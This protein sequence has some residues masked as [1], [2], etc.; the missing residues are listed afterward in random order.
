MS[1]LVTVLIDSTEDVEGNLTVR[2]VKGY[3]IMII[4]YIAAL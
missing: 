4:I 2:F 3:K 1:A